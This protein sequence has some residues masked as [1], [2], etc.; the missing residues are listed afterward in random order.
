MQQTSADMENVPAIFLMSHSGRYSNSVKGSILSINIYMTKPR[1]ESK[2][3]TGTGIAV[4]RYINDYFL[5]T[6]T[7]LVTGAVLNSLFL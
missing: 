2:I 4:I 3:P 7:V 6:V 1:Y 5:I